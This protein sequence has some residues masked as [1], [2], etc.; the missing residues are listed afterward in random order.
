MRL[1]VFINVQ[2]MRKIKGIKI[3]SLL[4]KIIWYVVMYIIIEQTYLSD[5]IF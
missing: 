2:I 3:L 1:G 5:C 4:V